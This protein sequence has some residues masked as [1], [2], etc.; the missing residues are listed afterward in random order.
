[1]PSPLPLLI[2]SEEH[3][4]IAISLLI[5]AALKLGHVDLV[6]T[7]VASEYRPCLRVEATHDDGLMHA[8]QSHTKKEKTGNLYVARKVH[9]YLAKSCDL[10]LVVCLGEGRTH[11]HC[12]SCLKVFDGIANVSIFRRLDCSSENLLR[13]IAS[14]Q[15]N[16]EN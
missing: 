15:L 6:N 7:S 12:T 8:F 2:D 4:A 5:I 11:S 16:L 10:W 1:M 9:K 3:D 14:P 13:L